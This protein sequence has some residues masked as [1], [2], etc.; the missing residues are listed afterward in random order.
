MTLSGN[1]Q[2]VVKQLDAVD[3]ISAN[4]SNFQMDSGTPTYSI[5]VTGDTQAKISGFKL[6]AG[7]ATRWETT[8]ISRRKC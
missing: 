8:G 5:V 3:G 6:S 7:G 2:N 1:L 4:L